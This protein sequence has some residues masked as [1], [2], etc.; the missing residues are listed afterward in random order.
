MYGDNTQEKNNLPAEVHLRVRHESAS[1][2]KDGNN[3]IRNFRQKLGSTSW[4][5]F[6]FNRFRITD[7]D[8]CDEASS[9]DNS[10]YNIMWLG[11]TT[12]E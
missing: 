11:T 2:F 7:K 3:N 6:E 1:Y 9:N 8:K 12:S 5:K 10:K 4:Q